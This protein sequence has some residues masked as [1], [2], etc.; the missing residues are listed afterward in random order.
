MPRKTKEK[1]PKEKSPKDSEPESED[2]V[3]DKAAINRLLQNALDEANARAEQ[4]LEE[5]LT[6]LREEINQKHQEEMIE[7]QDQFAQS[8][9]ANP[10]TK[11]TQM[12]PHSAGSNDR[13]C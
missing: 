9:G 13:Y 12:M 3:M 1:S 6:A 2:P 7:L 4:K 5:R 10:T 8:R 11:E